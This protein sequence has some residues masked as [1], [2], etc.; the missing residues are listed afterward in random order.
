MGN[1]CTE[2]EQFDDSQKDPNDG[3]HRQYNVSRCMRLH[4]L[5]SPT[6]R[7]GG[8]NYNFRT[9]I[10]NK[11]NLLTNPILGPRLHEEEAMTRLQFP[12][13][14]LRAT[15]L[16][17]LTLHE[18]EA[19]TRRRSKEQEHQ[20]HNDQHTHNN[21]VRRHTTNVAEPT[22]TTKDLYSC[23]QCDNNE[24]AKHKKNHDALIKTET[25]KC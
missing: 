12:Q 9:T 7:R 5:R 24:P 1:D 14:A 16:E 8:D 18:E 3:I 13:Q 10:S 19:T 4:R 2:H 6:C 15:K 22:K 17:H 21:R 25:P 23:H 11:I 20:L